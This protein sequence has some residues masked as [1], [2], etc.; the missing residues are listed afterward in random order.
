MKRIGERNDNYISES[1]LKERYNQAI[2]HGQVFF[3]KNYCLFQNHNVT[4]F[5]AGVVRL[6]AVDY[7]CQ[8]NESA[9]TVLFFDRSS[10]QWTTK[11]LTPYIFQFGVAVSFDG[12]YLFAQ[13]WESGL[14]CLDAKTGERVWKTKSRRG[15]TNVFVND[16]TILC[17]QRERALQLIDLHTGEVL[18][19]KRPATAWGFTGIDHSHVVC[20]VTAKRWEV[21]DA[22]TLETKAT[23]SHRDFTGKHEDYVVNHIRLDGGV[24]TARGFKNVWD[25]ASSEPLPNLEFEHQQP[26]KADTK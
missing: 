16:N 14:L 17:H 5:D 20:R 2:E 12:K 13:T 6:I 22:E 25:D 11:W 7:D 23:Y 26:F 3:H 8:R 4:A 1:I 24:L 15:I 10:A 9:V 19:E 18:K 21:I